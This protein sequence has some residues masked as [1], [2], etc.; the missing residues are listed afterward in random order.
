[1]FKTWIVVSVEDMFGTSFSFPFGKSPICLPQ[2]LAKVNSSSLNSKTRYTSL[3]LKTDHL[4]S[5]AVSFDGFSFMF[6]SAKFLKN[7]SKSQENHKI[8][9]PV[10]LN[11][12]LVDLHS[13][14]KI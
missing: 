3:S 9:N 2:L 4:T 10:V 8:E 14:H 5:M 11:S 12:A 13:K 6:I 7:H 1:M